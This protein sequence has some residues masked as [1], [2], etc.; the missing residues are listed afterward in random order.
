MNE[1][2]D[3]CFFCGEWFSELVLDQ[4]WVKASG[5]GYVSKPACK[6]CRQRIEDRSRLDQ[7]AAKAPKT[8]QLLME[9]DKWQ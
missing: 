7:G 9:G 8:K 1:A 2:V 4:I 3:K 5:G 6:T